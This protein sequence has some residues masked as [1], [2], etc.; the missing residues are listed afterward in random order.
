MNLFITPIERKNLTK[1][2]NL[3]PFRHSATILQMFVVQV[4]PLIKGT[5]I[6]NLSYFSSVNYEV[7]TFVKVPIRN[8]TYR[9]IVISSKTVAEEKSQLRGAGFTLH[10]LPEQ[11]SI[12]SIPACL[13]DTAKKLSDLYP[14]TVGAILY[15]ILSP[16]VRT[17]E[18]Q[19]PNVSSLT[20]NEEAIPQILTDTI[21]NRY[22][23]YRSYIRSVLAR[24]GS[25]MF[26]VPNS[27]DLDYAVQHLSNGIEDRIVKFSPNQSKKERRLAYEAFEDTTIAKVIITT[28]THAYLDRVDLLSIIIERSASNLYKSRTR[29]YLDQR[30]ALIKHAETTGRSILLGDIL[31]RTEEEYRRRQEFYSTYNEETKRIAFPTPL[32]I[33]EQNDKPTADLPFSLFSPELKRRTNST[34]EGRG[35]VFMY[36][37]RRGISPVVICIDCGFIFRCPDSNTPYSLMRTFNEHGE[38]ERWFVSSTSGRRVR[39]SDTCDKCGS[40][41][42]QQR[43]IGIQQ[44]YDECVNNFPDNLVLLFD[45]ITAST[46]KKAENIINEFYTKRGVILVGTQMSLPYLTEK[47]VDLSAVISLDATRANPTWRADEDVLRLLLELREITHKEVVVQTRSKPDILLSYATTGSLDNFYTDEISLREQ[48]GYPPFSTFILLSYAGNK[49]VVEETEQQIKRLTRAFD[50]SYYSNPFS[51]DDKILRYAL[52]RITNTSKNLTEF[53]Q[54]IQ[55][56]PPY[57]KMEIDPNRIV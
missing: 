52:F 2:P 29:P 38:E 44:V 37:A 53:I 27:V 30:T 45:N 6:N 19:Y 51:H 31:P 13:R 8:K 3:T 5:K 49:S 22:I 32:T 20:H 41:R 39:A 26:V 23:S 43:G 7:G 33:I 1:T 54:I 46:R 11:T 14:A 16:D 12:S 10:K 21:N 15:Q 50:G 4:T 17:G 25:V 42:L 35:R 56:L 24:R 18:Y 9:A 57:I 48:L 36:G 47:G 28:P 55:T 40:W 34:L